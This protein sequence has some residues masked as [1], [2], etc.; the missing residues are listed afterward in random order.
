MNSR[1]GLTEEPLRCMKGPLRAVRVEFTREWWQQGRVLVSCSYQR[2]LFLPFHLFC[3]A[4]TAGL[5]SRPQGDGKKG[6]RCV[7]RWPQRAKCYAR[8]QTGSARKDRWVKGWGLWGSQIKPWR[9]FYGGLWKRLAGS[10]QAVC[11]P[12][13]P[14]DALSGSSFRN[15]PSTHTNLDKPR[16]ELCGTP[17]ACDNKRS[18][19][20]AAMLSEVLG[21]AD[22]K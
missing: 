2:A 15:H 21:M 5:G 10:F 3:Q 20:T 6:G 8:Y 19:G 4:G 18:G 1:H 16:T 17:Q 14:V 9:S 12:H 11:S 7:W 22:G 13:R